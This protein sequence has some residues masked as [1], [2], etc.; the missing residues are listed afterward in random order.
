MLNNRLFIIYNLY[1]I[2][3]SIFENVSYIKDIRYILY[4]I[5]VILH[6]G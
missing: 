4:N 5:F 1:R 6:F 3:A 2:T